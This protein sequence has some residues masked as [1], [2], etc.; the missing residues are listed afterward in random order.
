MTKRMKKT[1]SE[2]ETFSIRSLS[3]EMIVMIMERLP[4]MEL[5][6]FTEAMYPAT[7]CIW[8]YRYRNGHAIKQMCPELNE[9]D[10]VILKT[11]IRK[12]KM[13]SITC[14]RLSKFILFPHLPERLYPLD[15]KDSDFSV[16]RT[17]VIEYHTSRWKCSPIK[18]RALSRGRM[19]YAKSPISLYEY[20]NYVRKHNNAKQMSC[21][22]PIS[23]QYYINLFTSLKKIPASM[24]V[25]KM[26]ARIENDLVMFDEFPVAFEMENRV[27]P[28]A[29]IFV[30]DV[31]S[32]KEAETWICREG[33]NIRYT[34]QTEP[35]VIVFIY[36]RKIRD[37]QIILQGENLLLEK[38]VPTIVFYSSIP[39]AGIQYT[40]AASINTGRKGKRKKSESGLKGISTSTFDGLQVAEFRTPL[41]LS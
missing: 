15:K 29:V 24:I 31:L 5:E 36:K 10:N 2:S 30:P 6:A 32:E 39:S 4:M 8:K 9:I 25:C 7:F 14:E 27:V 16:P 11:L 12:Y 26:K 34:I 17:I 35:M 20:K 22:I 41:S 37:V 40:S 21:T 3:T 38:R 19:P 23:G 1:E 33:V 13:F 18:N 28:I